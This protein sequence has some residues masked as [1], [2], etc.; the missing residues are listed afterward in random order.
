MSEKKSNGLSVSFRVDSG[1]LDHNNRVITAKFPTIMNTSKNR[2]RVSCSMK[3]WCSLEI[4]TTAELARRIG[5]Q[6]R[7]CSTSICENLKNEI[8]T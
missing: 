3:S 6:R 7:L 5:K 4:C 2:A 1:F 8:P